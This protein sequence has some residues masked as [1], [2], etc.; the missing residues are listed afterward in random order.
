MNVV[1]IGNG[2]VGGNL[3][4]SLSDEGHSIT[5]V[6]VKADALKRIQNSHD[7]MCIEGNGAT[8]EVQKEANVGKAGLL[9]AATPYD[10]LN[11]LC[12]LI[13][14]RLGCKKTIPRV[15]NPAYF[16]QIDLIREDLGLSMVINPEL[17][18]AEEFAR[19]L[20]FPTAAKVEVFEKGR[21]ELVEH[22]LAEDSTLDGLTLAEI[23]K[24]T[25]IRFLICAVQR[26]SKIFIPTGDFIL[27]SGDRINIAA[28]HKDLE[29]FFRMCGALKDKIKTVMIVGGGKICYY[30]SKQLLSIGMRVKIIERDYN[31][32]TEIAELLPKATV[33]HGDGTDQ[34]LLEE[35][36]IQDADSFV[37]IT[38]IDE[39]N[40]IMSLYA[41]MNTNAKVITKVNRDSYVDLASQIGLDTVISPKYITTSNVLSYVRSQSSAIDSNIESLYHLVSNRVEAIEFK[42]RENI[43]GVVGINLMDMSLKK[44]ILICAIVRKRDIIIPSGMDRI[45]IGDSVVVVSKEHRISELKDI[46]E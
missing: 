45:D 13:A 20:I 26:D 41:R 7:V 27:R 23:Y 5:V 6:D 40:I 2:K 24:R 8:L 12:C 39:E 15:R 43:P 3:A 34:D 46:L 14:K 28:S 16:S 44:N 1:I 25:N 9:I 11:M 35:E 33:I 17:T 10:E 31:R 18:T 42:V 36:G 37:A 21:V 19:V 29:R 4:S 22:K 38:G 32:C 30:L